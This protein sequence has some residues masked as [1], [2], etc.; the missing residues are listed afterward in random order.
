MALSAE[1]QALRERSGEVNSNEGMVSFL[2][3]LMRDYLPCG[4]V[5]R[6]VRDHVD[7]GEKDSEFCNG[8]L[9]NYAKDLAE[10]IKKAG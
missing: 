7:F 10:R 1:S 5:E 8:F 2:Y 6:L 9:E 3:I 4:V